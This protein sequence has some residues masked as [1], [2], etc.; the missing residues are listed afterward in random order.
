MSSP[1]V[2]WVDG[3]P[4]AGKALWVDWLDLG[5]QA[6]GALGVDGGHEQGHF[7]GVAHAE[8]MHGLHELAPHHDGNAVTVQEGLD[9]QRF[10]LVAAAPPLDQARG[11]GPGSAGPGMRDEL[12]SELERC[13]V[14]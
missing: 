11:R 1:A 13:D 10:R 2:R 7:P 5:E 3:P 6:T 12:D 8:R 14:S 4:N 9:D